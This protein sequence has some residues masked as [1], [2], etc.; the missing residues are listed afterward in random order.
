MRGLLQGS[1][2][3][4]HGILLGAHGQTRRGE[5]R[6]RRRLDLEHVMQ[7]DGLECGAQVVESVRVAAEDLEVKIEL[8][9]RGQ[10]EL[11]SGIG[12]RP[13]RYLT[14]RSL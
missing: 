3:E 12:F 2:R 13:A 7:R 1:E 6:F 9:S 11:Q 10:R 4:Q 8:R 5:A 14:T